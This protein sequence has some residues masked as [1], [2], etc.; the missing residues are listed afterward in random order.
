MV[1]AAVAVVVVVVGG[2]V[3]VVTVGRGSGSDKKRCNTRVRFTHRDSPLCYSTTA[4]MYVY[5]YL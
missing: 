2:A 4:H 3:A 5:M 1:V